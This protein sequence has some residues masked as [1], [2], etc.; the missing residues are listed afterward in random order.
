VLPTA[1]VLV[2]K[3]GDL[4]RSV[5]SIWFH[6]WES[7][8]STESRYGY[9]SASPR[10]WKVRPCDPYGSK[11]SDR[12]SDRDT[13]FIRG[14]RGSCGN[15]IRCHWFTFVIREL[16]R[17]HLS[18]VR[19]VYGLVSSRFRGRYPFRSPTRLTSIS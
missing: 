1:T 8:P 19:S 9:I 3:T 16:H 2:R 18:C 7:L 17:N 11:W 12:Y 4:K 13:A 6:D 15:R 14:T 10:R 5:D